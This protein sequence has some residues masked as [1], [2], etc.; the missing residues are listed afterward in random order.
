MSQA[1]KT[2]TKTPSQPDKLGSGA[3][4]GISG[5]TSFDWHDGDQAPQ[6]SKH[7][8]GFEG[9]KHTGMTAGKQIQGYDGPSKPG[10]DSAREAYGNASL[11]KSVYQNIVKSMLGGKLR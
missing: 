6:Y 11:D 9:I 2:V 5:S 1:H 7:L 3:A 8:R 10:S 4:D